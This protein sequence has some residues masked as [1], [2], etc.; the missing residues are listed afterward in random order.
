MKRIACLL[1][2]GLAL[3]PALAGAQAKTRPIHQK[4]QPCKV[5]GLDEEVLCG[6]LAVWENRATKTGRKIDLKIV[7][8]PAKSENPLPDPVIYFQGGP[9]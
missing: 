6:T 2:C 5:E 4:L 9:G 3:L 8:V 7:V 1:L